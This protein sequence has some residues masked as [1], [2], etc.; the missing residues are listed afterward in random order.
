M[1]IRPVIYDEVENFLNPHSYPFEKR[2]NLL[3]FKK[4]NRQS[5]TFVGTNDM[6]VVSL[7]KNV[8]CID[9]D[10]LYEMWFWKGDKCDITSTDNFEFQKYKF[11]SSYRSG[12]EK[13]FLVSIT[14]EIDAEK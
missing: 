9:S 3:P 4:I 1:V 11:S 14:L 12:I 2:M 5:P 13:P 6:T 10:P 8:I 7:K